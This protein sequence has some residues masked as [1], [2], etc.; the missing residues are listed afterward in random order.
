[1]DMGL[2]LYGSFLME[3]SAEN[4]RRV[5]V[6]WDSLWDFNT[7]HKETFFFK[8]DRKGRMLLYPYEEICCTCHMTEFFF[9]TGLSF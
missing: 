3:L 7:K 9:G 1:M 6:G 2:E 8:V 4:I 5:M